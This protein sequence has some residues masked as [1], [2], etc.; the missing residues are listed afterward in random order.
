MKKIFFSTL[1]LLLAPL[2]LSCGGS[3]HD[4]SGDDDPAHVL[5]FS[6]FETPADIDG[7][8]GIQEEDLSGEPSPGGGERSVHVYGGCIQPTAHLV[9]EPRDVDAVYSLS[10]WAKLTAGSSPG[11]V[12]LATDGDYETRKVTSLEVD[13]DEWS[14]LRSEEA[15]ACPAG[16]GMRI[17]IWIGGIKGGSVLIDRLTVDSVE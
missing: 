8:V 4:P 14:F 13:S 16:L 10:L 3:C 11:A 1:L 6:S 7:W 17:E 5:Y 2:V 12:S 15:I 9:L